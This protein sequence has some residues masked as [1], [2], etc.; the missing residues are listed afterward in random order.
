M[1]GIII[2]IYIYIYM[3]KFIILYLTYKSGQLLQLVS[4]YHVHVV[5]TYHAAVFLHYNSCM[6][7]YHHH[8]HACVAT[9][10]LCIHF[11]TQI[12]SYAATS[13][14]AHAACNNVC[15]YI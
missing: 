14:H 6:H 13:M 4:W 7:G 8:M 11:Y 12:Y 2:A 10:S 5:A 15:V 1:H 3:L 9:S